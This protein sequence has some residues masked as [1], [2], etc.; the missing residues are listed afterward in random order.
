MH[1]RSS[2]CAPLLAK[3]LA[4]P[5]VQYVHARELVQRPRL[6][7]FLLQRATATIA[8]SSYTA[9]LAFELGAPAD[10]LH[11]IPP[12]VD[13]QHVSP[14][15]RESPPTLVTVARLDDEYK[16]HDVVLQAMRRIRA[17]VPDA[18]WIVVG[19]GALRAKLEREARAHGLTEAVEFR[20]AVPDAERDLVLDS[21]DVFVMAS[22]VPPGGAGGEGFGMVYLEA[23]ARGLPIVA[24][25][26]G[27]AV[28]AVDDGLTGLLIDP[29][30][31]HEVADAVLRL[32]TDRD[33]ARAIGQ[34]GI[35]WSRNFAWPA[36]IERVEEVLHQVR[37][38]HAWPEGRGS[39]A[40]QECPE[41]SS[42]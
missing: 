38:A 13:L 15:P 5:F 18:R 28:D 34:A 10:R 22:R 12:G 11:T 39:R 14:R 3:T 27:G 19:E 31:P 26:A 41:K 9:G 24:G 4:I 8:V 33:Q 6:A 7:R 2:Y 17:V 1:L 30:S 35:E 29:E 21:A 32:L 25:R 16:G 23:S 42:R 40:A 37:A 20:G 36:I